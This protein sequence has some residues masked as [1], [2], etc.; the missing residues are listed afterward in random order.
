MDGKN[1]EPYT[2]VLNKI[3]DDLEINPYELCILSA[4]IRYYNADKGYSYPS[5]KKL[6]NASK[7]KKD[8]TII[9]YV[10]S[11][12]AKGYISKETLPG[13]GC[14][15]FISKELLPTPQTEY[16]HKR[17]TSTNGGTPTPQTEYNN[18]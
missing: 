8:E 6:K 13:I 7:I 4:L 15:Y 2:K 1:V 18:N 11:L 9:L 12:I 3:Y 10:N 17:S 16:P 14:H 5:Y